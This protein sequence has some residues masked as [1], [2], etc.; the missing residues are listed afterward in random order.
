MRR[1]PISLIAATALMLAMAIPASA[2][3]RTVTPPGNTDAKIGW[4]GSLALPANG[5][6]LI[7][8]GPDGTWMLSPSHAN[9]LVTACHANES[10]PSVVDIRGPGGP[11]CEHGQ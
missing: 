11:G 9:G 2:H 5:Q 7:P 10:N 1:S 8:G 4:S 3:V 6:G